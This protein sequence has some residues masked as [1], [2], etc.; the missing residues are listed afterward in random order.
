MMRRFLSMG[1]HHIMP[2]CSPY[3][4][5]MLTKELPFCPAL[6]IAG[7]RSNGRTRKKLMFAMCSAQVRLGSPSPLC[8]QPV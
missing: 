3:V 5:D 1:M 7:T 8:A 2:P 6:W 4:K